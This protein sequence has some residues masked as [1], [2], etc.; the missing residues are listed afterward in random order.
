[1]EWYVRKL[2]GIIATLKL[3]GTQ[4]QVL[5]I[6]Q[7]QKLEVVNLVFGNNSIYFYG[8]SFQN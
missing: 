1:M 6:L 8:W 2:A 5:Q 7:I 4:K 3:T